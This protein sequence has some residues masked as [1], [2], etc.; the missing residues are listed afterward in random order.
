MEVEVTAANRDLHSGVYGGAV[1]NPINVLA[2]MIA[3]MHDENGKITVEGFY[4][5]VVELTTEERDA[6]ESAPFDL[7]AYK[8]TLKSTK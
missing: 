5:K 7:E 4:D 3:S 1:A 6:L 8:K 2:Q